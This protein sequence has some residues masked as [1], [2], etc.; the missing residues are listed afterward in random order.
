MW[1][2][3]G[4]GVKN[5]STQY[6]TA[7]PLSA[8]GGTGVSMIFSMIFYPPWR[9]KLVSI[10]WFILFIPHLY[11]FPIPGV[12]LKKSSICTALFFAV[13]E[14]HVRIFLLHAFECHCHS[15][16][17]RRLDF[18]EIIPGACLLRLGL[19][20]HP[21]L[22]MD[23]GF[24]FLCLKHLLKSLDPLKFFLYIY[25]LSRG[26]LFLFQK[27]NPKPWQDPLLEHCSDVLHLACLLS[28]L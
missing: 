5:V 4:I 16:A 24:S 27:Q 25:G 20:L 13:I 22:L 6:H 15:Q 19:T 8:N 1:H 17:L 2:F 3:G 26:S 7:R 23:H 18:L 9:L 11:T 12:F 10:L 21:P 14:D 28:L